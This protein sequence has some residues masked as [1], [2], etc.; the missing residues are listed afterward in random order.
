MNT[1][2]RILI[3]YDDKECFQ[4]TDAIASLCTLGV[5]VCTRSGSQFM[6]AHYATQMKQIWSL[7]T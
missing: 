2:Q 7:G 6:I 1:I 3:E 4:R 5:A